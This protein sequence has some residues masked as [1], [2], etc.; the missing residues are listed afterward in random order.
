MTPYHVSRDAQ[1][2]GAGKGEGIGF[3]REEAPLTVSL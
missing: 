3:G 1:V 2:G